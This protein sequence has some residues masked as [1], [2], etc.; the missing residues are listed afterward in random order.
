MGLQAQL[1]ELLAHEHAPLA[2]AQQASGVAAPA[3]LFTSILNYRHTRRAGRQVVLAWRV[4]RWSTDAE[5][6]NY[7]L[8]VSVDDTGDWVLAH[9][10]TWCRRVTRQ[11]VCALLDTAAAGL[12]AA[13]EEARLTLLRAGGG[14]GCGGA[15]RR[16]WR[17][18]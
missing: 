15:V 13:L 10:R 12:V 9:R 4:A 1:A 17:V 11:Q 14:A 5:R 16:W 7:P 8:T 3:P 18:E 2:V 6:T